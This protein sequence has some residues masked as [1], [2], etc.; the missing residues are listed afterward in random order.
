MID[1]VEDLLAEAEKIQDTQTKVKFIMN[2]QIKI[3][4]HMMLRL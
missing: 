4:K 3:Y 1:N 2:Y